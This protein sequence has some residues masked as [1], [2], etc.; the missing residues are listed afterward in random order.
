MYIIYNIFL[1]LISLH[2]SLKYLIV[3][4]TELNLYYILITL[5]DIKIYKLF[6]R[7]F[8]DKGYPNS[9]MLL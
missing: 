5:V 4:I 9:I 6:S 1:L 8:F 3:E 7:M 2:W